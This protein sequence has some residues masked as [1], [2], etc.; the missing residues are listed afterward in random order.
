MKDI[1]LSKINFVLLLFCFE[2][3][4]Y[5]VALGWS[6]THP[7]DQT[8]LEFKRSACQLPR[9]WGESAPPSLVELRLK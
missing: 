3:G 7:V 8:S 1:V 5:C 6:G 2:I 4:F 9:C